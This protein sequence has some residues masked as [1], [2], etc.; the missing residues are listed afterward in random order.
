MVPTE[1]NGERKFG[2]WKRISSGKLV[3]NEEHCIYVF[4]NFSKYFEEFYIKD[5]SVSD[6]QVTIYKIMV[7]IG[8]FLLVIAFGYVV[9]GLIRLNKADSG[10]KDE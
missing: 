4:R 5:N 9:P 1:E 6:R 3:H 7:L 10:M 2:L 8:V